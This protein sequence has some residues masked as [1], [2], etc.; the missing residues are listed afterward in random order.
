M[1]LI[2][3]SDISNICVAHIE[4]ERTFRYNPRS[5][6][7]WIWSRIASITNIR[8]HISSNIIH[9][10]I[11]RN[12]FNILTILDRFFLGFSHMTFGVVSYV[13]CFVYVFHVK[14]NCEDLWSQAYLAAIW[15]RKNR[16]WIDTCCV[17]KC[18][19]LMLIGGYYYKYCVVFPREFRLQQ[20]F[21]NTCKY[22]QNALAIETHAVF[23][24]IEPFYFELSFFLYGLIDYKVLIF[25]TNF[26]LAFI[27]Y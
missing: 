21:A 25:R 23:L 8:I 27:L 7:G 5:D 19:I 18:V 17:V 13:E 22:S 1:A 15:Q 16:E 10:L 6:V 12:I 26:R 24:C 9:F 3:I 11:F 4:R 2:L 20:H 14:N